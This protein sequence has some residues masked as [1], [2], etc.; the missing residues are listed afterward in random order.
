MERR[1]RNGTEPE[2]QT[3]TKLRGLERNG[4]KEPKRQT[5]RRILMFYIPIKKTESQLILYN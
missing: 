3:E 5:E 2:Q 4:T 1:N